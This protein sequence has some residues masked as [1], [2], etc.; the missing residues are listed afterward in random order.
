MFGEFSPQS[1]AAKRKGLAK[2]ERYQYLFFVATKGDRRRQGSK[3]RSSPYCIE[4]MTYIAAPYQAY[5]QL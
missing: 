4:C 3:S 2:G 5:H 1:D